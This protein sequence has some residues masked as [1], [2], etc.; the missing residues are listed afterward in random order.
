M[1]QLR[2]R[3]CSTAGQTSQLAKASPDSHVE[4][5]TIA[6][7]IAGSSRTTVV[8]LY[9]TVSIDDQYSKSYTGFSKNPL[10]NCYDDPERQTPPSDLQ[11]NLA[12]CPTANLCEYFTP[13]KFMRAAGA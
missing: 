5:E 1:S 11:E 12:P 4:A 2:L 10:L 3:Y 9:V 13:V 8:W 6:V 7:C